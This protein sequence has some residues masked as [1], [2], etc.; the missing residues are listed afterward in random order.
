MATSASPIDIDRVQKDWR[1]RGFGFAVWADPP[2]QVWKN[3][4]H[5]TDEL[6]M[7]TEGA[8]EIEI[9]GKVI[10]LSVGEEV[11]IP[12]KTLHTVRNAGEGMATWLYGYRHF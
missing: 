9:L 7:L 11:L 5:E 2:D 12:A 8:V 6:V 3:Y 4:Q 10:R 1:S